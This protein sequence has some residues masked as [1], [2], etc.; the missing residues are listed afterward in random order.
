MT[1]TPALIGA[2]ALATV[3]IA[4]SLSAQ[5]AL[6]DEVRVRDGIVH[7]GMAYEISEKCGSIRA[8]TF[9]GI[10]F[11]QELKNY[12]LAQGYSEADVEAYVS[13]KE[14]ERRLI[15]IARAQL[16]RLGVVEGDEASYCAVGRDQIDRNTRVGW[17][18]R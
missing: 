8:R 11:L 6:K 10:G 15:G 7:V 14:E 2:I 1:K 12:A 17:L 4:G 16:A 9:R 18:L 3:T 5:T 13:D